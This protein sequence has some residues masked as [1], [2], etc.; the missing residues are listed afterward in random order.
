MRK[1]TGYIVLILILNACS[2]VPIRVDVA[3]EALT[4]FE[5]DLF[6]QTDIRDVKVVIILDNIFGPSLIDP[7]I[8]VDGEKVASLNQGE[9]V[10]VYLAPGMHRLAWSALTEGNY[11]EQ[12][13]IIG[14]DY[15]NIFHIVSP[16][17]GV[18]RY[19]REK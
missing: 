9:K 6:N 12:E 7:Q 4:K 17:G 11:R 19:I 5:T 16:A 1:L 8:Y 10:T 18:L 13:F 15:K 14:K 2:S 3:T